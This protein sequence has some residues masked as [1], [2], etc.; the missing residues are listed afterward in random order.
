M[1]QWS[2]DFPHAYKTIALHPSST[3]AAQICFLN[4][5][6]NR[7]CK[8]RILAQPFGSRRAPANWG[9]MVTFL[10]FSV[11]D[12]LS[13]AAGA[14]VVDVFFSESKVLARSGFW[15]FKRLCALLGFNTSGRK[16]Q[17]PSASMHLLGAEVSLL[18]GAIC[19]R[20][21][22]AR[23]QKLRAHISQVLL[24]EFLTP[25]GASKLRGR[26]GFTPH[27]SWGDL[28]AE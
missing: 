4:H 25:S 18:S 20:A 12:L 22:D 3:E 26:L 23:V 1:E 24:A 17:P 28:V 8:C 27:F 9:R 15:A 14:Y 6:D 2:V 13:L 7:P 11:R 19:T 21:T 10:Q 5:V 16:G